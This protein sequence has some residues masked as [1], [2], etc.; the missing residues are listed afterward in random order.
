MTQ[1][2]LPILVSITAAVLIV[3][4]IALCRSSARADASAARL[5]MVALARRRIH[6]DE[7]VSSSNV[8]RPA[9]QP[10]AN[11]RLTSTAARADTCAPV[12]PASLSG[13]TGRVSVGRPPGVA[14]QPPPS[15][16]RREQLAGPRQ[17]PFTPPATSS[18]AVVSGL[19]PPTVK[20]TLDRP[21]PA[22]RSS[23]T[24]VDRSCTPA[25]SPRSRNT[26]S[27]PSANQ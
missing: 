1:Q 6:W 14:A 17:R 8:G 16:R 7:Q 15:A 9:P 11:E 2:L 18:P 10:S 12:R 25:H 26:G 23:P 5:E 20:G 19:E 3:L 24:A 22:A 4:A 21:S 13:R 27:T